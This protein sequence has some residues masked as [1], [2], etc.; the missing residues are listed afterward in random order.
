MIEIECWDSDSLSK[1]DLIGSV[2]IPLMETLNKTQTDDWYQLVY[3][4]KP[5]GQIRIQ[6]T[7]RPKMGHSF[8]SQF[9]N[10]IPG[11]N[12][13]GYPMNGYSNQNNHV[14][15]NFYGNQNVPY[16]NIPQNLYNQYPPNMYA[17]NVNTGYMNG[18]PP[19]NPYPQSNNS[20]YLPY[21]SVPNQNPYI[22]P[23]GGYYASYPQSGPFK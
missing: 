13:Q 15:S 18:Y 20:G 4:G 8:N 7:W 14:G 22:L 12:P 9:T 16:P 19:F 3:Q 11:L 5:A 23:N 10:A 17:P 2:T 1:D 6:M 21:S